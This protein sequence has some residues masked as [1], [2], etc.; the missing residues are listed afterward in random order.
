[1]SKPTGLA[2][3][4]VRKTTSPE[5]APGMGVPAPARRTRGKGPTVALTIRLPRAEWARL[6]QLAVA[7]GVS[8]Q[9]LVLEGLSRVFTERG[10]P[11]LTL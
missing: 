10:L 1:M 9:Q 11:S 8:L 2:A 5:V 4:T 6:H 3:F 7:E